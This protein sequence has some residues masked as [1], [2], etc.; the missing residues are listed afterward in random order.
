MA[1]LWMWGVVVF[2]LVS[3]I[4]YFRKFWHKVDVKVKHRRRRELFILVRQ[5][6]LE[7]LAQ[8]TAMRRQQQRNVATENR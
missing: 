7:W 2:G 6:R 1:D 3:A 8:R 4:D 5:R